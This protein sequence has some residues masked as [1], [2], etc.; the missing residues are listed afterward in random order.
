MV[1][2]GENNDAVAQPVVGLDFSFKPAIPFLI[3]I[4]VLLIRRRVLPVPARDRRRQSV[5]IDP[6]ATLLHCSR[7]LASPLRSFSSLNLEYGL[8]GVLELR[9]GALRLHRCVHGRR[10][11]HPG[12]A[13]AW[14]ARRRSHRGANLGQAA[15]ANGDHP[16]AAGRR[17]TNF[18][19]TLLIAA[20][21][22]GLIG[23]LAA[24]PALRLG[25]SGSWGLYSWHR[26]RWCASSCAARNRSSAHNGL[27]GISQPSS[28]CRRRFCAPAFTGLT[29]VAAR[30]CYWFAQRI[31]RSPYGRMLRQ[32]ARTATSPPVWASPWH[33][34]ASVMIVGSA[35][36]MAGVFFVT[37][38][39]FASTNDYAVGLTL[40]IWR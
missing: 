33:A 3:I 21:I 17:L 30:F 16:H 18:F 4:L 24:Y 15:G 8:G 11:L 34:R 6:V 22:G 37:N 14:P 35:M 32:C 23:Y 27:S 7:P 13:I 40:D 12:H 1:A 10:H 2:F 20:A 9:Q 29:L 36:A 38:V 25:M 5:S 28:G 26:A 31:A 39:G 19:V